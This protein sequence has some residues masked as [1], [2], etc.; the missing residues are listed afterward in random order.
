[1]HFGHLRPYSNEGLSLFKTI[2]TPLV[3][4]TLSIQI[5]IAD[6]LALRLWMRRKYSDE[7]EQRRIGL[8]QWF[9]ALLYKLYTV[10]KSEWVPSVV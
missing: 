9:R 2:F 3:W 8:V 7:D 5:H 4:G 10:G 6:T 1:M